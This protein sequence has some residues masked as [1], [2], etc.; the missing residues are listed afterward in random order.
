MESIFD[1]VGFAGLA[2]ASQ[3]HDG[4]SDKD[5]ERPAG[6]EFWVSDNGATNHTTSDARNVYEWVEI[7]PEKRKVMIGDGEAMRLIGVGSLNLRMH[8]KTD[9]DV[10]LTGVYVTEGIRFNLF[11]LHQT[12]ARQTII[13]DKEG[14]HLFDRQLTFSRDK[15]GSCLYSFG[16]DPDCRTY[17]GARFYWCSTPPPS[18]GAQPFP[19]S[20]SQ[21][22]FPF[23]CP[24]F[25][26][27]GAEPSGFG[28]E[29]LSHRR[30]EV[31]MAADL[32]FPPAVSGIV[33]SDSSFPPT[34]TGVVPTESCFPPPTAAVSAE[35]SVLCTPQSLAEPSPEVEQGA[36]G[37]RSLVP[38]PGMQ[39]LNMSVFTDVE[40]MD[41]HDETNYTHSP[42]PR[43]QHRGS[44]SP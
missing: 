10:K 4:A 39:A 13:L 5:T 20:C 12:Q 40:L 9:F 15:I 38:A 34:V 33:P 26:V 16:P 32:G 44:A 14:A 29:P 1:G 6:S 41:D 21:P 22:P 3:N 31:G 27:G 11:S 28:F 35:P 36:V 43:T 25:R 18:C 24:S 19:P 37:I 7:P 8:S 17:C 2:L 23:G 42:P 30:V